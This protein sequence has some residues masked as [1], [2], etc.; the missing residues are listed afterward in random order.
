[1]N[2]LHKG[3]NV[4]VIIIIIN[5]NVYVLSHNLHLQK[6]KNK[7]EITSELLTHILSSFEEISHLY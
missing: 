4:I 5:E 1:V 7:S 6:K 2:T 3:D